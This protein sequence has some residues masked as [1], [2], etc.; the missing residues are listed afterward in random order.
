MMVV[1]PVVAPRAIAVAAPPMERDV[2]FALKSVATLLVVVMLPPLIAM[3]PLVVMFPEAPAMEK[4][5]AV[6]SFAPRE[7]AL[8]ISASERSRALVMP[9]PED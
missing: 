2:A 5:E 1:V 6:T 7:R 8:M 4:L 3:S 9:P